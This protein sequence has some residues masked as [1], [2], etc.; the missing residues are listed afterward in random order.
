MAEE[1]RGSRRNGADRLVIGLGNSLR[2]DDGVGWYVAAALA[3][4]VEAGTLS[5]LAVLAV[6]QLTPELVEPI[7]AARALVLVD[8][9][10]TA[11]AT[12]PDTTEARAAAP[13]RLEPLAPEG[14]GRT[15]LSHHTAPVALL[16]LARTLHGRVPPTWQLLIP[17][18]AAATGF[19]EE[20][21]PAAGA[22]LAEA[23]TLLEAWARRA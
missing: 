14:P 2:Q 23:V 22:R 1:M 11:E 16:A 3:R 5:G 9:V 17:V 7:A 12:G 4:R 21:S 10:F 20:L 19:G 13:L 6:P 18:A 15:P 8:A